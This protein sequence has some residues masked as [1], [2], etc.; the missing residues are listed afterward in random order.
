MDDIAKLK[1]DVATL[2]R[3]VNAAKR[4]VAE[5]QK[6]LTE[7]GEIQKRL[8]VE[9]R[10]LLMTDIINAAPEKGATWH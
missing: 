4:D 8:L 10:G 3:Q 6:S 5:L 2:T 1:Q 7:R 9:K